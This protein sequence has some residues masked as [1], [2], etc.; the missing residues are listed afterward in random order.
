MLVGLPG[1]GKST[2]IDKN[3]DTNVSLAS[4]DWHIEKVA[5]ILGATYSEVFDGVI[6]FADRAF[7]NSLATYA[8]NSM[9]I[10]VDRTNLTRN[11]RAKVMNAIKKNAKEQYSFVSYTFVTPDDMEHMNRLAKRH[12]KYI[13]D[14]VMAAM[15]KSHEKAELKEG[16]DLMY[17]VYPNGD[18]VRT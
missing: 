6:K 15:T 10:V 9:D 18:V 11:S 5:E 13:P 12:G 17:D 14:E 7:Y 16:F 1:V 3:I 8:F 4:S 2:W